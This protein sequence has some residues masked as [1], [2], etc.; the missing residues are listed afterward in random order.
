MRSI[1]R[2]LNSA[3]KCTRGRQGLPVDGKM[4]VDVIEGVMPTSIALVDFANLSPQGTLAGLVARDLSE[5]TVLRADVVTALGPELAWLSLDEVAQACVREFLGA[6]PVLL[7]GYCSTA[8][9]TLRVAAKLNE[10]GC[11]PA[12]VLIAPT[13]LTADSIKDEFREV[14]T[15]L[16]AIDD[17]DAPLERGS[18]SAVLRE[19]LVREL[20]VE[21]FDE[22]EVAMGAEAVLARYEAWFYFL[23]MTH[24]GS[25]D[26]PGQG[27]GGHLT[28][29]SGD[30][31]PARASAQ[32]LPFVASQRLPVNDDDILQSA[33]TSSAIRSILT[34]GSTQRNTR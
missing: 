8:A 33:A 31:L 27:F 34:G 13:W 32:D 16:N 17:Y 26:D 14:R 28:I 25:F 21:G 2:V 20:R 29:L 19:D 22:D 10:N 5:Y 6:D 18:F 30:P 4:I 7:V 12:V 1:S 11:H 15:S 9:L 23:L 3:R 24:R